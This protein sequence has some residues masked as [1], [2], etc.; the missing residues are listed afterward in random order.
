[1]HVRVVIPHYFQELKAGEQIEVGEGFGCRQPGARQRRSIAF[2]Q[3]LLGLIN[4][5][6][7]RQQL[8]LDLV[9]AQPESFDM[10]AHAGLDEE[11]SIEIVVV[12]HSQQTC[13]DAVL[14]SN[15]QYLRVLPCP[16][17]DPQALGL[18]ARDY[19]IHHPDPADLN[20]YIED[21]LVVHDYLFL[22]KL[23]G[24]AVATEYE[25]VLMP[26]RY[27]LLPVSHRSSKLLVDGHIEFEGACEW[28]VPEAGVFFNRFLGGQMISFDR[29]ANPHAGFFG[30]S[31]Y[32][33]ESIAHQELP[34]TGFVGP[35]ETAATLTPGS[36]FQIFKTSLSDASFFWIEH[37]FPSFL[38]YS[39]R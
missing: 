5:R 39:R 21:D 12:I 25:S 4:L 38:G 30:L 23:L 34:L 20:L 14:L 19:L 36:F 35:L 6:R 28:H 15:H 11:I 16:S 37:A 33:L 10:R 1:M 8:I 3:C 29:P 31:K 17:V 24:L 32:Q 18:S 7:S 13:L 9:S 26:H 2:Q 27:E 22:D